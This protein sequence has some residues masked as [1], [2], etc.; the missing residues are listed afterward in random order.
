MITEPSEESPMTKT[1]MTNQRRVILEELRGLKTHPTADE[2]YSLV[3]VRVPRIS[4]GTV[5]RNLE[6]LSESGEILKLDTLGGVRRYDG[7]THPHMHVRC[8]CCG[9]VADVEGCGEFMPRP[10]S[11]HAE[12]FSISSV[13]VEFD[14]LCD[15]CASGMGDGKNASL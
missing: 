7:F 4:L 15:S 6:F 12:G 9:R 14:G 5:Y 8:M 11:A 1:R 2:I 10:E 13:R 3:K